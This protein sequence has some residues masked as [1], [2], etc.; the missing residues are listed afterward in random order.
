MI[1]KLIVAFLGLSIISLTI[2]NRFLRD[3][4]PKGIDDFNETLLKEGYNQF[5]ILFDDT[6][7]GNPLFKLYILQRMGLGY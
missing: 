3:R 5:R 1:N 6:L 7:P 4:I 2:W